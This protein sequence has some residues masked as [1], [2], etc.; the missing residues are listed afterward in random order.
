MGWIC[1]EK[2]F[3]LRLR[4]IRIFFVVL[5]MRRRDVAPLPLGKDL[6]PRTNSCWIMMTYLKGQKIYIIEIFDKQDIFQSF[7]AAK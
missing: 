3:F 4:F 5:E 2:I 7:K 1:L 6:L